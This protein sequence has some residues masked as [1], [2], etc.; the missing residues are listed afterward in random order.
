MII[1]P[2]DPMVMLLVVRRSSCEVTPHVLETYRS[3]K[4]VLPLPLM[5][6]AAL[7]VNRNSS[8]AFTYVPF[9]DKLVLKSTR[10]GLPLMWMYAPA[11]TL[12]YPLGEMKL[13]PFC[14]DVINPARMNAKNKIRF[15][16]FGILII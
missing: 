1:L 12:K 4:V 9:M 2:P 7:P 8:E 6:C 13:F 16:I 11:G 3:F 15:F 5:V 10:E 14:A